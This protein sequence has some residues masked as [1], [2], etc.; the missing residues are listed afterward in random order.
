M[1]P[2]PN[3]SSA[4][5]APGF[6]RSIAFRLGAACAG[7]MTLGAASLSALELPL[8]PGAELMAKDAPSDRAIRLPVGPV[9]RIGDGPEPFE[10]SVSREAWASASSDLTTLQILDPLRSALTGDGY[11]IIYDCADVDCGGFDFRYAL[12]LLPEPEMHVDLGDFRYLHAISSD[13]TQHVA[14]LVS[15]STQAGYVH[16][17]RV[18]PLGSFPQSTVPVVS[19][20]PPHTPTPTPTLRPIAEDLVQKGYSVLED[21]RFEPGSSDLAE[22]PYPSL[23]DLAVFLRDNPGY[24]I[25]FV[26]HTD[27]VGALE[28][29]IALSRRRAEAVAERL[30][31]AHGIPAERVF[32]SGVGFL[33][34]RASNATD[35]GRAANRRVEAVILLPA[36]Q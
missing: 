21:V 8:P 17:T 32:S 4:F 35:D 12:D 23:V 16:I 19:A 13:E 6:A 1:R 29:N 30:I 3:S 34:P 25:F 33:A 14:L 26:G 31:A 20:A 18:G 36:A 27:A 22:A 28:T 9:S 10:G 24:R 2:F 15:R 7:L 5:V 11:R